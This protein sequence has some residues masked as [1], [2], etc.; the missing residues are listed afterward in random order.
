[1]LVPPPSTRFCSLSIKVREIV[2]QKKRSTIHQCIKFTF[3]LGEESVE[4]EDQ[5]VVAPEEV[6]DPLNH[7]WGIDSVKGR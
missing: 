5:L 4:S 1:M 7:S 2:K 6:L 3:A